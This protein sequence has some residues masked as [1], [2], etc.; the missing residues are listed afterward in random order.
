M[1]IEE[2]HE[3]GGNDHNQPDQ[4][5]DRSGGA[6]LYLYDFPFFSHASYLRAILPR[7]RLGQSL[8][9]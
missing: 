9:G 3:D 5:R 7:L 1:P 2:H 4:P 8:V 6:A